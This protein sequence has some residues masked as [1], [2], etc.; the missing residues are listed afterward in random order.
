[1]K[2]ILIL[3]IL[4]AFTLYFSGCNKT[5]VAAKN[6]TDLITLNSWIISQADFD[7]GFTPIT[8]YKK[9]ATNSLLDV[10]K[11]SLTFKK[12]GSISATDLDGKGISG[13][14]AF[15]SDETKITLPP[16]LPFKD[17]NLNNLTEKNLDVSV[18]GFKYTVVGTN[19]SGNLT[20]KMI[21]K[22]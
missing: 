11:I 16:G 21:P 3:I 14:W 20:I 13:T 1:M 15:N 22:F 7:P 17:V 18:P 6:K 12:D 8:I 9:D 5:K 10:S 2:K 19:V 4:C